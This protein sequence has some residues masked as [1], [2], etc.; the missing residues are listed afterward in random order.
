MT[1]IARVRQASTPLL[2]TCHLRARKEIAYW[3]IRQ[4]CARARRAG[5]EKMESKMASPA[6]ILG[7]YARVLPA[8]KLREAIFPSFALSHV[9]RRR[10][11]ILFFCKKRTWAIKRNYISKDG[12]GSCDVHPPRPVIVD[13]HCASFSLARDVVRSRRPVPRRGES[14]KFCYARGWR[15]SCQTLTQTLTSHH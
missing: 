12:E 9:G 4:G 14:R 3:A 6:C 15:T 11:V 2:P 1:D 13:N 7:L 10:S 5:R 8:R